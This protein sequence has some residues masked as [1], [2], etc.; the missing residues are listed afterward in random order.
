MGQKVNPISFRLG[1]N[2]EHDSLWYDNKNYAKKFH[3]DLKVKALVRKSLKKAGVSSI[4]I[5]RIANKIIKVLISIAMPGMAIGRSGSEVDKL[6]KAIANITANEV[7]ISISEERRAD[8]SAPLVASN[9]ARQLEN[10]VSFRK[11]VKRAMQTTMRMGA[12][13]MK[14]MVSGRL[15]GAEIARSET[16]KEGRVPLHTIKACIDYNLAE[17]HTTYGVLGVKVWIY[18]GD[19]VT[20]KKQ[21][22]VLEERENVVAE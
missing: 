10:R 5:E 22:E 9:I 11:A 20:Y 15:G 8:M 12:L 2:T 19:K 3:E 18:K 6:K 4:K 13:G 17:A 7:I 16:F 1:I 21:E 14:V